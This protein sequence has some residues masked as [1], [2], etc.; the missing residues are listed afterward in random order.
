MWIEMS[1]QA[2]ISAAGLSRPARALWIEIVRVST[3]TSANASRPA[4]A[5]WIEI[6]RKSIVVIFVIVE[7]REGLVD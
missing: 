6:V 1:A 4:R 5:L 2:A 7:A 3:R